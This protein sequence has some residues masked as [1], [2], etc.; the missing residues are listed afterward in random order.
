MD[1]EDCP[2]VLEF[3]VNEYAS[4]MECPS[5][6]INLVIEHIHNKTAIR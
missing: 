4:I 5:E 2:N 1:V 3:E 6:N